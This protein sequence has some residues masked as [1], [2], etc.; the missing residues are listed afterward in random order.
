MPIHFQTQSDPI[1]WI[2]FSGSITEREFDVYLETMTRYVTRDLPTLFLYDA[3]QAEVPTATQR[4][5]QATWL[6]R[7]E[8]ALRRNSRG[9]AFVIGNPLVRG[10]LTAIFWI[11]PTPVAH[12]VVGTRAEAERWARGVIG[13][14][15]HHSV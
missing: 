6:E 3:L 12:I 8:A 7:N 11:R 1:I 14:A 9:T 13:G 10:A 2:H 4:Q 5:K 15:V